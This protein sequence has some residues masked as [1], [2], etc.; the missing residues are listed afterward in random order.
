MQFILRNV[1]DILKLI[2]ATVTIIYF[3]GCLW[4][5]ISDTLNSDYNNENEITF[6][7]ANGLDEYPDDFA[8]FITSAYFVITTLA[9]IGYGDIYPKSNVEKIFDIIIMI[10]GV[11]FFTYIMGNFI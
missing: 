4:F 1:F 7:R 3:M 6:I 2:I 8:R 11:A 10:F 5:I 9:V